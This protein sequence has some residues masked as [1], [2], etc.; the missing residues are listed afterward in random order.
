MTEEQSPQIRG[1]G[2]SRAQFGQ[3]RDSDDDC[4]DFSSSLIKLQLTNYQ[5]Q[6]LISCLS[7]QSVSSVL[8]FRLRLG[9]SAP[10]VVKRFSPCIPSVSVARFCFVFA[11]GFLCA[12]SV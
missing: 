3:E 7:V 8:R 2:I 12:L 5:L 4:V 11:F 10:S 9:C 6:I 1:S